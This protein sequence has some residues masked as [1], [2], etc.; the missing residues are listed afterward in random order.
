MKTI[1]V[2]SKLPGEPA[3][4]ETIPDDFRA[5]Q[6]RVGG[7]F[8]IARPARGFV[9][10]VNDCS[11]INGMSFDFLFNGYPFFGPAIITGENGPDLADVPLSEAAARTLFPDIIF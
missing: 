8:D 3:K 5:L 7:C 2:I 9:V 11:A 6:E 10:I 1:R 4:F